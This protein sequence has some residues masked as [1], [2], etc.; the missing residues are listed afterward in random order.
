MTSGTE[1][2]AGGR[3]I[4]CTLPSSRRRRGR[5][6]SDVPPP[7]PVLP[8]R[9]GRQHLARCR[10]CH[11]VRRPPAPTP[12]TC[13]CKSCRRQRAMGAEWTSCWVWGSRGSRKRRPAPAPG[14]WAVREAQEPARRRCIPLPLGSSPPRPCLHCCRRRHAPSRPRRRLLR[15]VAHLPGGGRPS[16]PLQLLCTHPCAACATRRCRVSRCTAATP[17]PAPRVTLRCTERA[18]T[19][20]PRLQCWGSQ[21]ARCAKPCDMTSHLRAAVGAA[22][23]ASAAGMRQRCAAASAP[24]RRHQRLSVLWVHPRGAQAAPSL[25]VR[26]KPA[27]APPQWPAG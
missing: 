19:S 6:S 2:G 10:S 1:A 17:S 16:T 27:S 12:A 25:A 20:H 14:R 24:A 22:P 11:R 26:R 13:P 15:R 9:W 21:Q 8:R 4:T 18:T 7:L 5:W 3:L 23:L